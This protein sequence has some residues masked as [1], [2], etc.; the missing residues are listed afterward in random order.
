VREEIRKS[1]RRDNGQTGAE[2]TEM[3]QDQNRGKRRTDKSLCVE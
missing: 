2:I 1:E 3:G